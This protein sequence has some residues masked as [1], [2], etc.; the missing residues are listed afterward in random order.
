MEEYWVQEHLKLLPGFLTMKEGAFYS[1]PYFSVTLSQLLSHF[2]RLSLRTDKIIS[3]G[4]KW[5]G[6]IQLLVELQFLHYSL[7]S[8][9][10]PFSVNFNRDSLFESGLQIFL[11]HT[12]DLDVS[13][14][15]PPVHQ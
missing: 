14:I 2:K 3:L 10:S 1:T 15:P 7:K 6:L 4:V 9:I 13:S 12:F 11:K 5:V 8:S